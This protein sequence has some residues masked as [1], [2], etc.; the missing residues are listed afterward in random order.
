MGWRKGK[1]W[2]GGRNKLCYIIMLTALKGIN[3]CILHY[4]EKKSGHEYKR[5]VT[6]VIYLYLIVNYI[7]L[8]TGY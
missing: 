8:C 7:T 1:G 5:T 2:D 3:A 6:Q 4:T